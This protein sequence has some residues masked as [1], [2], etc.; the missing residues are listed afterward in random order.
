VPFLNVPAFERQYT[1]FLA[2]L[3]RAGA[4]RFC[5]IIF[6]MVS[7]GLRRLSYRDSTIA[8]PFVGASCPIEVDSSDSEIQQLALSYL[9]GL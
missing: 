6:S 8:N 4:S 3:F 7:E 1:V 9:S 5:S 2:K